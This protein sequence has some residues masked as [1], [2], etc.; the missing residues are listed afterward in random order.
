MTCMA[1]TPCNAACV[2]H[3]QVLLCTGLHCMNS[4]SYWQGNIF[5]V[6]D[7]CL[8]IPHCI[9]IAVAQDCQAVP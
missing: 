6:L 3:R 4:K 9:F 7:C 8:I 2:V 1:V 5:V